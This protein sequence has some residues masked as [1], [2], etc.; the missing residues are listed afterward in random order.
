MK[1]KIKDLTR[2]ER[3]KLCN[4]YDDCSHCPF[5]NGEYCWLAVDSF[6]EVE[7]DE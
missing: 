7:V 6:Y 4:K 1:K 2:E 5:K 3:N